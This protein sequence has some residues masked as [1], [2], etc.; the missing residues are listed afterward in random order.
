MA[1]TYD[2]TI[3]KLGLCI[4]VHIPQHFYMLHNQERVLLAVKVIDDNFVAGNE[5]TRQS[6]LEGLSDV[7]ELITITHLPRTCLFFRLNVS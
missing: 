7:Y 1:I 3:M 4:I 2:I 6:F 5:S